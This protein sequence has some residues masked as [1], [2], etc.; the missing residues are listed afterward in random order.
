MSHP[1]RTIPWLMVA[2]LATGVGIAVAPARDRGSG[3]RVDYTVTNQWPGGFGADVTITNLG[4]RRQ[5]LDPDL[6]VHRRAD[7]HPGLERGDDPERRPGDRHRTSAT[8]AAIATGA[9]TVVRLQRLVERQ[10]PGPGALRAQRRHLHRRHVDADHQPD[11]HADPPRRTADAHRHAGRPRRPPTTPPAGRRQV[12]KLDRGLISV[13]SGSG[14]LVS[15]RLLGTEP[16]STGVQRLPRRHQ[17]ERVA[18]HRLDQLPRR[19]RRRRRRLHG[20]RG[21]QRRRAGARRRRRCSSRNGY[22]DVPISAARQH[23]RATLRPTTPASATSTAT[24]SYEIVL[25]WDPTNAKDNSQS[26]VHRQRLRRRVQARRHPA[27]A[28]RPRPQHPRRRALHPVPGV[29]LRRRRQGRGRHEDRRRHRSTAPARSSATPPPT[30][31]TPPATSCPGPE[32]LTMFNGQTGAAMSTVNYVPPRGTV[33]SLGRQL[34]QPGRPVP[35]RHRLPGRRSGPALIMARGYYT[36]TVIAAWDFRNGALTRRWTFDSNSVRQQ[37]LRRAGQP[38]AVRR[39]RR[40]RRQATRSSTARWP[41]TTTAPACGTPAPATAT[42]CTSATSIPSRAGLEVLQGRRGRQPSRPRWMA[43]ARTGADPLAA[44][45][46]AVRQ[47]PRRRPATSAPAA[48]APSRG[49]PPTRRLRNTTGANVG[50]K[51]GSTNFLAWWDGDPVRELL[52]GTHIDKYGTGGDTRLLTGSGVHSNN[53][54]KSTPSLSGDLLG[55]WREEVIWP[56][57]RQHGAAHLRHADRDQ[58]RGS[59]PCCTTRSTGSRSPGRTP[60]T[61][62]RRTRVLPRHA[63]H[64]ARP[65]ED[66]HPLIYAAGRTVAPSWRSDRRPWRRVTTETT[67]RYDSPADLWTDALP[68]G[69][70]RLGAMVF[71]GVAVERLQLNDDTC[72][73]GAPRSGSAPDGPAALAA[74]REAL[75]R[76]DVREAERQVQRLQGGFVQAYQPL[77]DLWLEQSEAPDGYERWLRLDEGVAGQSW[78]SGTQEAFVSHPA[79]VVVVHRTWSGGPLRVRVTSEHPLDRADRRRLR[80]VGHAAHAVGRTAR[81]RAGDARDPRPQPRDQHHRGRRAR[82][83]H[84][85]RRRRRSGRAACSA[86]RRGRPSSSPPSTDYAGPTTP[87]HGDADALRARAVTTAATAAARGVA[88]LRDEHVADHA[89]LFDRVTLDLRERGEPS[90]PPTSASVGTRPASPTPGSPPSRSTYGR[91]LLIAGSRPGH[92]AR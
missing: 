83:G 52:D 89:R 15:W 67:L 53:G 7:G 82:G 75:E 62:S 77:V 59:T 3:C 84:R 74:A 46:P 70:G 23:R 1:R 8:T 88:A 14:N 60:P 63:V 25:K 33:S 20:P 86:T 80:L 73:S 40:R 29:R 39:R 91:Y 87:L 72:W 35:G 85:R 38:P 34:R 90:C 68:L 27:V 66:Q 43:D 22:L 61:T 76:G 21:G 13:R 48:P 17:G 50:R 45:R 24:A 16:A 54:T 2:T 26:G 49:R 81:L 9:S 71:G 6:V 58:H 30:T 19:R 51:P 55:D 31:A 5:R 4:R 12:E 36:R 42:P 10:Q 57:S 28:H 78:A 37:Q 64:A 69:N 18:D 32:F 44:R 47:R 56:T 79:S 65:A 11:D 41:S 92:A